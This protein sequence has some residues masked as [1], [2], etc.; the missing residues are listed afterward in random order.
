MTR[1]RMA[2]PAAATAGILLLP[3]LLVI[4]FAADAFPV[5]APPTTRARTTSLQAINKVFVAGGSKG[6][7]RCIVEKLVANGKQVVALVRRADVCAELNQMAGVT[8]ILG[9]AFIIK[10]VENAMDGCDA[11][12]TTLGGTTQDANGNDQRIDYVGNNHVI[13]SAGILGVTRVILVTSIGCG[14]SKAA[15][16][17]NVF[18]VLKDVLAAKEKAENVLIKYYT[19]MDW[20]IIRPGG[21][22]SEPATGR[23]ILTR[24]NTVIGAIHREDVADLVVRALENT[25]TYRQVFSALDQTVSSPSTA[26]EGQE[27]QIEAFAL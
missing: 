3:M 2:L 7:G 11:A 22:K 24:D 18:A 19:N 16:P 4:L 8:A 25:N 21:L 12:I 26:V 9:D 27:R 1:S 5:A 20:T 13:E 10:D 6:V 17:P 15:A 23:A 14:D